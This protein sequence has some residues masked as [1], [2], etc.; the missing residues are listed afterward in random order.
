MTTSASTTAGARGGTA[1]P[2]P[3]RW[4]EP[5]LLLPAQLMLIPVYAIGTDA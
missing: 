3:C 1:A 4:P 2:P 5:G